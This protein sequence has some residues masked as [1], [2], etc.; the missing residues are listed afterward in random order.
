[1]PPCTPQGSRDG[2]EGGSS[3]DVDDCN[4]DNVAAV[5][6]FFNSKILPSGKGSSKPCG[7]LISMMSLSLNSP[8]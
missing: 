2:K 7:I 3:G 8:C 5:A 1:M 4:N 6:G